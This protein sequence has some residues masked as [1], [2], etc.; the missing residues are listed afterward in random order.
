L[1]LLSFSL[2]YAN[3]LII[4]YNCINQEASLLFF[5]MQ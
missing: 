2:S 4:W 5:I 3:I 1:Y